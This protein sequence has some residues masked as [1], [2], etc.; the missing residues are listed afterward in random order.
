MDNK[1]DFSEQPILIEDIKIIVEKVRVEGNGVILLTGPSSCGKGEI[2]KSLCKFLSLSE[3]RHLSMGN[4]L[5][6]T[7]TKAKECS[8]FRDKLSKE[9]NIDESVSIFDPNKNKPEIINKAESYMDDLSSLYFSANGVISQLDWLEFCV[10]KGLLVPD[11]WTQKIIDALFD[12]SPELQSGII[13]LDGYP[14]TVT[15]AKFL[16]K[17]F[18]RLNIPVIKVLHLSI[19]KQQMKIRALN[20]SRMDDTE[21]TLER[22]YLFFIDKVQ[23]CIDYLKQ[24]LGSS[25]VLLIDAHQPVFSVDGFLDIDASILEVTLSVMQA[26]GLPGFLLD[27]KD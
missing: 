25:N 24:C 8:S 15:A 5:R 17:T 3:D 27:I 23:P 12:S 16:L 18:S 7:I 26:L 14:R 13:I 2:A 22:R 21:D 10:N 11:E 9:Y 20:R 4:I 19:T 6:R 1:N